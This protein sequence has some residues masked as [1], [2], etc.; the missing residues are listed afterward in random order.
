MFGVLKGMKSGRD[1]RGRVWKTEWVTSIYLHFSQVT[2]DTNWENRVKQFVFNFQQGTK[3]RGKWRGQFSIMT[4]RWW[5]WPRTVG[6]LVWVG[7]ASRSTVATW[8]CGRGW[9]RR[10]E[11]ILKPCEPNCIKV[12]R[13]GLETCII[14]LT[15]SASIVYLYRQQFLHTEVFTKGSSPTL[16]PAWS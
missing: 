10:R 16:Q 1:K 7:T 5:C 13:K 14:C 11:E 9:G 4:T 8:V 2:G 15:A 3:K 12:D 6:L